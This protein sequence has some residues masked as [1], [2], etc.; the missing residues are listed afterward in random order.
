ML[1]KQVDS[2]GRIILD[3]SYAG[4]T[5]LVERHDDGS[6]VLRPAV[7]VPVAEAWLWQNKRALNMVQEGLA[8]A[9]TGRHAQPP[10]L[11]AAA[12][13]AAQIED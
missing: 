12:K 4:T 3:K 13:L 5:M 9:K 11:A 8:E 1:T 10:D 7:T 6:I 2:K